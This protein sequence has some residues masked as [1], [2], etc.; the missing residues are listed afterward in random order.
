[1]VGANWV[2]IWYLPPI[3]GSRNNHWLIWL[4]GPLLSG[5]PFCASFS[6]HRPGFREGPGINCITVHLG[7]KTSAIWVPGTHTFMSIH[8]MD[9][10]KWIK[11]G[12]TYFSSFCS[13]GNGKLFWLTKLLSG[14]Q[15]LNSLS[16]LGAWNTL[17]QTQHRP[18]KT[19]LGRLRSFW[20]GLFS[21]A[22]LVLGRVKQL[23]LCKWS[24]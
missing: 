17:P 21:G 19:V 5:L 18:S 23:Q 24:Y 1:M 10:Y 13:K 3:K 4:A 11:R 8:T 9:L 6:N 14:R 7:S 16:R 22:L 2:I 12:S 20:G 15:S